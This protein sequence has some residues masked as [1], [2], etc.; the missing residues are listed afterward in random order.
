MPTHQRA[1]ALLT[2]L[3]IMI[4]ACEPDALTDVTQQQTDTRTEPDDSSSYLLATDSTGLIAALQTPNGSTIQFVEVRDGT[5]VGVLIVEEGDPG[6][7]VME[8]VVAAAGRDLNAAELYEA[9]AEPA[10]TI[11]ARLRD[12]VTASGDSRA[13][14]WALDLLA[15]SPAAALAAS[16]QI[17]CDNANFTSQI[18]GG[19]LARNFKRLDTGPSFHPAIWPSY[20]FDGFAHYWY[21]TWADDTPRWRGKVCGRAGFH[22]QVDGWLTTTPVLKFLY[23]SGQ[24]WKQAGSSRTFGSANRVFAW[25]YDGELGAIDWR[26]QIYDAYLYDEFDIMMSWK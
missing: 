9:F 25:K 21:Q 12:V 8:R 16:N 19:F 3:L 1:A 22:P 23:R 17:A 24:S 11:P 2:V 13:V 10:S 18:A 6:T 7:L 5:H 15:S 26:I 4:A 20:D 14:G